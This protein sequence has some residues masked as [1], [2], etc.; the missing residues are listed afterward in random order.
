MEH[1]IAARAQ[2]GT[3]LA[4]H[5]VFAALGVGLPLLVCTAEGLWLRTNNRAYYDLAR[6]WTKG[7]AILFAVGAV[8][9]TILSFELGLLWPQF[10]KFAGGIIGL[11]FSLEGF[12]FFIEAI[13]IG[14]Y[15]YGWDKLSPRMHWLSALPIVISG[16]LS[17]SF[18]TM[19][20]AWMQM[21]TGFRVVAGDVTDVHPLVAMF[22]KPWATEVV[23]ATLAAYVFTSFAVAG[24]CAVAWLRGDRRAQITKGMQVA[25]TVAAIALPLQMVVGDVAARFVAENEPAK[26]AAMEAVYHTQADAPITIGGIPGDDHITGAIEIPGLLSY[27][28]AF[29]FQA[30][31]TGFDKIAKDDRPPIAA[32][33]LSFDTMVGSA[34]LLM[35]V[36]LA[37]LYFTVR[38]RPPSRP[39]GIAIALSAPLS[40]AALEAGWFVTEFGRQP[41]IARGLLRTSDAVTVAPGVDLQFY[42]FSLIYVVLAAM[43]W[44]L[45][46][47]VDHH[48]VQADRRARRPRNVPAAS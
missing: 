10:M 38:R 48:S 42:G 13:F 20:N 27:L 46:R 5:I 24:V 33:H 36:V 15:L 3:S 40:L 41:W 8:S 25:M 26:F 18:I 34:S 14:L 9:G 32:T 1:V 29:N 35:L 4:F 7:M 31:I 17:A 30:V 47:R 43:S 11:P 45:L 37:W 23:H 39:L 19:A 21:P 16:P 28:V 12:A 2:M 6:V 22:A 44:W